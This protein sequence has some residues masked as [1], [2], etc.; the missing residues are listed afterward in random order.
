[1]QARRR[2]GFTNFRRGL[3]QNQLVERQI[4]DRAAKAGILGLQLLHPLDPIRLQVAE[5]PASAVLTHLCHAN[6]AD[7]VGN[8]LTLRN[9]RI[10]V[11]QLRDDI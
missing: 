5:L 11:L 6:R 8:G 4:R 2:A 1:M 3:L 10:E 7:R 9:Q